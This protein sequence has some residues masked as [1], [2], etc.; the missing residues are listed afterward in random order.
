MGSVMEEIEMIAELSQSLARSK[1]GDNEGKN[2]CG[3]HYEHEIRRDEGS[4]RATLRY[5]GLARRP[6]AAG[7][8]LIELLMVVVVIGIIVSIAVLNI[9][10]SRR[11]ANGASAVSSMRVLSQ[12]QATYATGT[13]NQ[14]YGT[15][16]DLFREEMIDSSLAA[17][18]IPT[19]T[20]P[21]RGGIPPEP[22]KPKSG[23]VFDVNI[24]LA[25]GATPPSFQV[26]GHPLNASGVGRDGD[27]TFYVDNSG[28][29]RASNDPE[30]LADFNSSPIQ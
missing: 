13:G 26:Q 22:F 12:T 11:A 19:P 6:Q 3:R 23:F 20:T 4:P 21:S 15:P 1:S 25:G 5:E 17:A 18:C 8:S 28:V 14:N 16:Q 29:I 24:V 30:I 27:R 10:S 9:F 7:F 2:A